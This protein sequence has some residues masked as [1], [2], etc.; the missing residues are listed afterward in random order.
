M[1]TDTLQLINLIVTSVIIPLSGF[2]LRK[3]IV[4]GERQAVTSARLEHGDK[5]FTEFATKLAKIEAD[6]LRLE[7]EIEKLKARH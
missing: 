1:T 2:T 6:L 7:I 5:S 4:M 3:I